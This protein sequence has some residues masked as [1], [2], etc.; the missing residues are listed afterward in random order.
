MPGTSPDGSA[1]LE[2]WQMNYPIADLEVR[3]EQLEACKGF[4]AC[5]PRYLGCS[6]PVQAVVRDLVQLF[7]DSTIEAEER[8]RIL[9]ALAVTLYR[10]H[11]HQPAERREPSPARPTVPEEETWRKRLEQEEAVFV[12]RLKRL[13]GERQL[14]Q[15]AISMLLARKYRPQRRTVRLLAQV[16]GVPE[17][18]LWPEPAPREVGSHANGA[19]PVATPSL[20]PA[21]DRTP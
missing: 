2:N 5:L 12:T 18:E 1:L 21:A 11:E 4:A 9:Q 19:G 6:A 13:M 10:N 15:P 7:N 3:I 16:L 8:Q 17:D 14:T 20:A